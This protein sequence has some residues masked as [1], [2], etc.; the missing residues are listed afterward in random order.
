MRAG[1]GLLAGRPVP[2]LRVRV[3]RDRWGAPRGPLTA[4]E[5]ETE[6]RRP[7]EAGEIVVAGDHVQTGY[8][9][10]IGDEETKFRVGSEVWHRTGDAGAFDGA[11]RLWLLGRCAARIEDAH[12]VLYPFGTE[13]VA[14]TFPDV[15]RAALVAHAGRRV[16][17]VEAEE[18]PGL[19]EDLRRA[20]AGA[21]VAEVR[22]IA[23]M[24]VDARHNAKV[25][26]PRLRKWLG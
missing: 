8:L 22:F 21:A 18:R 13:C 23:A 11:G 10:G 5:L 4:A 1:R 19:A 12:G 17:V 16:L 24:P 6:T 25:D 3:V 14:M 9:D 7:G 15:R 2:T 26:Y 20:T